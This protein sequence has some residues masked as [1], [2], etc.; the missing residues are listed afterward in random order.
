MP[1]TSRSSPWAQPTDAPAELQPLARRCLPHPP[2]LFP[3]CLRDCAA[4]PVSLVL[5]LATTRSSRATASTGLNARKRPGA[6]PIDD[7]RRPAGTRWCAASPIPAMAQ[8]PASEAPVFCYL[9]SCRLAGRLFLTNTAKQLRHIFTE[10]P[11]REETG[12]RPGPVRR[13]IDEITQFRCCPKK[14]TA[15]WRN[16]PEIKVSPRTATGTARGDQP[17]QTRKQLKRARAAESAPDA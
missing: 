5:L 8:R 7:D 9:D 1:T 4:W 11:R 6:R 12:R 13:Y 3:W 15:D 2:Q 14:R 17:A 16:S 10:H